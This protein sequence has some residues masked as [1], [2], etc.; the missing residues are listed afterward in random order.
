MPL[1]IG[2]GSLDLCR[3]L[4][5]MGRRCVSRN[6]KHDIRCSPHL[7]E[8][9]SKAASRSYSLTREFTIKARTR[10]SLRLG[11]ALLSARRSLPPKTAKRSQILATQLPNTM[12]AS[13]P[14]VHIQ[15]YKS[16]GA[17]RESFAQPMAQPLP[18]ISQVLGEIHPPT[19]CR[20]TVPAPLT[21]TANPPTRHTTAFDLSSAPQTFDLE[22][23]ARSCEIP[24]DVT[25]HYAPY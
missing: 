1:P 24:S 21:M 10:I 18:P 11:R 16:I 22:G 15:P 17:K 3:W 7:V 23:C 2:N 5:P 6:K 14:V 8:K 20:A 25:T 9:L 13:R 19:Y 4:A 12:L